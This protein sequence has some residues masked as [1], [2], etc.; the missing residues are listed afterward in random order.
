MRK[1]KYS[2]IIDKYIERNRKLSKFEGFFCVCFES[3]AVT[4]IPLF[5]LSNLSPNKQNAEKRT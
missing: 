3:C 5:N 1:L 4:N 2:L